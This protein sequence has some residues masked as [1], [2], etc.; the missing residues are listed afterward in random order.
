VKGTAMA[1]PNGNKENLKSWKK[2][3]SGNPDGREP[4]LDQEIF[5]AFRREKWA[6]KKLI[7]DF[8][9]MTKAE[10]EQRLQTPDTPSIELIVGRCIERGVREADVLK[11]KALV[12]LAFG[13]MV[14]EPPDFPL[15]EDDKEAVRLYRKWKEEQAVQG[16]DGS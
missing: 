15:T 4:I 1:N 5:E 13:K 3:Q 8:L 12:E 9:N 14:D 10:L 6:T 2:G 7:S 16:A 11:F